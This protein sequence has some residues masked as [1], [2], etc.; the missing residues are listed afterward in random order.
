MFLK[1]RTNF[2]P[3]FDESS[4]VLHIQ[5]NDTLQKVRMEKG[6]YEEFLGI[7]GEFNG[8]SSADLDGKS[9]DYKRVLKFCLNQGLL[10]QPLHD[11][12]PFLLR[13]VENAYDDYRAVWDKIVSTPVDVIDAPPSISRLLNENG[14]QTGEGEKRTIR[15][16]DGDGHA[17]PGDFVILHD[18]GHHAFFIHENEGDLHLAKGLVKRERSGGPLELGKRVA[19]VR[20]L[21]EWVK[22]IVNPH[23]K[24]FVHVLYDTGESAVMGKADVTSTLP[25]YER[26]FLDV[27]PDLSFIQKLEGRWTSFHSLDVSINEGDPEF[28]V[29]LHVAPYEI[30]FQDF[31][32][33][34][35]DYEYKDAAIHALTRGIEGY[36]GSIDDSGWVADYS[37]ERFYIRGMIPFLGKTGEFVELAPL[38]ARYEE[39]IGSILTQTD[40]INKIAVIL[41]TLFRED[42]FVL[43]LVDQDRRVL[44]KGTAEIE[45]GREL[46]RAL[47]WVTGHL[48]NGLEVCEGTLDAVVRTIPFP[49]EQKPPSHIHTELTRELSDIPITESAWIYQGEVED[50]GLYVGKFERGDAG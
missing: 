28:P 35:I 37:K 18:N 7:L 36:L 15:W 43:Y 30:R 3:S 1:T 23:R 21:A 25:L 41:E 40:S 20:A 26:T 12:E 16:I 13:Y 38:P 42:V 4:D 24:K 45:L 48:L 47:A 39:R 6:L 10:D 32:H 29:H 17:D 9:T 44:Y 14:L 27:D 46:S 49:L 5:K 33:R 50:A 31:T 34:S 11:N 19:G 2:F 8:G 22:Y